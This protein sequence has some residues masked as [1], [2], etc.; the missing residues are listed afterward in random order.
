MSLSQGSATGVGSAS[1][2][3]RG[4]QSEGAMVMRGLY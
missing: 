1:A 3:A 4:E 2:S